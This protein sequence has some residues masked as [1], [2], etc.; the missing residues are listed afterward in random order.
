TIRIGLTRST[1]IENKGE[2]NPHSMLEDAAGKIL[3]FNYLPE[4]AIVEV[5]DGQMITAGTVI[6]KTP[7]DLGGT[8]D[9]TSGLPR[10]TEL[11]EARRPKDPAIIAEID[12]EI[13]LMAE[14]KRG[15]R[16]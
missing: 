2:R 14:K 4:K 10:V 16:V 6:A 7:R 13:D 5:P 9:I 8:Q 3:D 15:K 1:V 11:F 12:G